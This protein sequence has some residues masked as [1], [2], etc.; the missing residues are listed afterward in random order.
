M[1][2]LRKLFW[3]QPHTH[4]PN[5]SKGIVVTMMLNWYLYLSDFIINFAVKMYVHL[6]RKY[7]SNQSNSNLNIGQINVI[8]IEYPPSFLCV[9]TELTMNLY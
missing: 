2:I 8:L 7:R 9:Y 4:S 3:Y 6:N 1:N 5:I